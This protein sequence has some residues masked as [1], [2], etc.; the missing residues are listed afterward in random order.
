MPQFHPFS[1][2]IDLLSNPPR[3]IEAGEGCW[4]VDAEGNRLFDA[5]AGLWC[6]SL[7]FSNQR[8]IDAAT[9]QMSTLPWYHNFMGRS[10]GAA[11]RY[12]AALAEKLPDGIDHV[13]FGCTGTD[14][15]D[16]AVKIARFY[17]NARGKRDKKLIIARE[18]GYHGS[19]YASAALSAASY[20]H[21]DLD[22]PTHGVI[23]AASTHYRRHA[24]PGETEEQFSARRAAEIDAQIREVGADRVCALIGEPVIGSGGAIVP[25]K[26]YWESVQEVLDSYDV[27]LIADEIIC[28][29]GRTGRWFGSQTYGMRPHL[30]TMAKQMSSSYFPISGVGVH[31]D[32]YGVVAKHSHDLGLFGHGFTYGGHPVGAAVAMEA[33]RIYEE[34]DVERTVTEL[35]EHLGSRLE[36][37]AGRSGVFDV[38]RVG[39]LAAI[40]FDSVG[41]LGEVGTRIGTMAE[42]RGVIFRLLG[43]TLAISPPLVI[44]PTE[45]DMIMGVLTEV[46][47]ELDIV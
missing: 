22:V 41:E 42:S 37:I 30:M 39:L 10:A 20:M 19:G 4:V 6:M 31:D 36:G 35:G 45:I 1:D 16:S 18:E 32:V 40:E 27:L 38:R 11:E 7:G 2:P 9:A 24:A 21:E 13:F 28:G 46:L 29:F 14:A 33:L 23:R 12:G 25:P 26:G 34:M 43:D 44:T 8:L 47:D 15:V 5:A 3:V 17:Q